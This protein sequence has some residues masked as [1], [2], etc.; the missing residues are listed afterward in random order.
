[1]TNHAEEALRILGE[2]EAVVSMI[3]NAQSQNAADAY[4]KKA[5]GIWAQAQA[6][7]TLA[8]AEQQRIANLLTVYSMER[9]TGA[10]ETK[11]VRGDIANAALKAALRALG[12]NT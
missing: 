2:G 11:V 10:D 6:H 4:G 8:R 3:R 9:T 1:M 5:M 12:L 7:A